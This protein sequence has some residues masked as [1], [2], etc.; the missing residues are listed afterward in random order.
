MAA[1]ILRT[2]APVMFPGRAVKWAHVGALVS[3]SAERDDPPEPPVRRPGRVAVPS[4]L[5]PQQA[6]SPARL[7]SV[8]D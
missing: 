1:T 3:A 6:P 5:K 8:P 4:W 7:L 2:G